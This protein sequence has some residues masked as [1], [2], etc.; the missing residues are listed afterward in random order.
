MTKSIKDLETEL[1]AEKK[2]FDKLQ[3]RLRKCSSY[4]YE[5]ECLY[6]E[7]D[8]LREDILQLQMLIQDERRKKKREDEMKEI[9]GNNDL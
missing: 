3:K 8:A 7:A 2:R 5:Y 1:K 6:D 4:S 9:L